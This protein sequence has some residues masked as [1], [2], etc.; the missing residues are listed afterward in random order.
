MIKMIQV[1]EEFRKDLESAAKVLTEGGCKEVFVH[2]AVAAGTAKDHYDLDLAVRG[3]PPDQF[4]KLVGT[5]LGELEHNFQLVN[6]DWNN[7]MTK[8]IEKFGGLKRVK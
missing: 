3:C 1:Q 5:L 2:G 6:L 8:Q 7:R 4:F